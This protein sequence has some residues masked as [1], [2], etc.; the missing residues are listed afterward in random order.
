M[1]VMCE[2]A[3]RNHLF[4]AKLSSTYPLHTYILSYARIIPIPTT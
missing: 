3:Q 2:L 4:L 1:L